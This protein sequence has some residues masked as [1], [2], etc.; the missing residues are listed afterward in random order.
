M[1]KSSLKS[2]DHIERLGVDV[3]GDILV[4]LV[5]ISKSTESI[6]DIDFP[7]SISCSDSNE[8]IAKKL[9]ERFIKPSY[10]PAGKKSLF[11]WNR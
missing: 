2:I 5:R 11:R 10:W 8:L 4:V 7:S 1:T 3:E 6:V 9:M